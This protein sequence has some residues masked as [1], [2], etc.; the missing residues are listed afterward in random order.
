LHDGEAWGGVLKIDGPRLVAQASLK[1]REDPAAFSSENS[2]T[3]PFRIISGM[4]GY[5]VDAGYA[6]KLLLVIVPP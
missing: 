4:V 1:Q 2:L 6:Q 5:F 3:M